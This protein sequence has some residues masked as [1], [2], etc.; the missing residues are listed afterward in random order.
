MAWALQFDGVNDYATFASVSIAG[1][2]TVSGR[3]KTPPVLATQILL[4]N[5]SSNNGF[6]ALFSNGTFEV[7][8]DG[9]A[10]SPRVS[11]L[12]S[13]TFY[14]FTLTRAGTSISF[15]VSTLT[16]QNYSNNDVLAFNSV[17]RFS[18]G[19]YFGGQ[20]ENITITDPLSSV[21]DRNW[22]ATASSHAAGTPI[23]TDTIGG[24]NATG[25]NMPTDGSAWV[26]LGGGGIVAKFTRTLPAPSATISGGFVFLLSA[27]WFTDADQG[28]AGSPIDGGTNSLANGGGDMKIFSDTTATTQLPIEVVSFVTGGSP[29]AQVWVRTPSYTA[30]DTITI[31][32]DDTQ[33]VQPAVGAAFGR[34][35]TWI[36]NSSTYHGNDLVD[37]TGNNVDLTAINGATTGAVSTLPTGSGF[38]LTTAS[39]QYLTSV[40]SETDDIRTVSAWVYSLG[41]AGLGQGVVSLETQGSNV[42]QRMVIQDNIANNPYR[43]QLSNGSGGALVDSNGAVY[44]TATM[45]TWASDGVN[46]E[47]YINGVSVGVSSIAS[48]AWALDKFYIGAWRNSG[49]TQFFNGDIGAVTVNKSRTSDDFIA[50]LYTNQSDPDNF[51]TSSEYILVG[52]GGISGTITQTAQSFTQSLSG[53]VINSYTGTITQNTQ[54]F[55]QSAS[56]SIT[57]EPITGVINQTVTAFTQSALGD[58]VSSGISGVINQTASAFTQSATGSAVLNISGVISQT[59]SAFTQS[60][61]GTVAEQISGTINQTVSSFTMSAVG[62]IPASWVDKLPA[63]TTW[64]D[65]TAI[66][67]IWTDK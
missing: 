61:S 58:V 65:Q 59:V 41:D 13:D 57:S 34:N 29:S 12:V 62:K 63:N 60:L 30:G 56:G 47:L 38:S 64:V 31:G 32:K 27:G 25:V 54:S 3:F 40:I 10:L 50:S 16:T 4:G 53:S 15:E 21:N 11:G 18:S 39:S 48:V 19:L 36:S 26:D 35:A 67:T 44:N 24:N 42:W 49:E 1:D 23:L 5:T 22:D 7:Q 14:D 51:G 37:S 43:V 28:A 8:I 46:L 2:F 66:S 6:I 17:G 55:T 52:G 45:M 20:V 33:T 9:T